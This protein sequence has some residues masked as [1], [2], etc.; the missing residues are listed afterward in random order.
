MP[1]SLAGGNRHIII[2]YSV[3][4]ATIGTDFSL[5]NAP[6]DCVIH[7]ASLTH[8][9]VGSDGGTVAVQLTLDSGTNAPGAG[10]DLLSNNSNTGFNLKATVNTPQYAAFKPGVSRKLIRGQRIGVD[11]NGTMTAVAGVQFTVVLNRLD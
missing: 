7:S 8:T 1:S 5:F 6:Y 4:A 3:P 11:W 9:V 2:N 10:T